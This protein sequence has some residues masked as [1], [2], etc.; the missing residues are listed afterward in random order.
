MKWC[1]FDIETRGQESDFVLGAVYSDQAQLTAGD[2]DTFVEVLKAHAQQGYVLVAHNAEFDVVNSLWRAGQD[3]TIH[4]YNSTFTTAYWFHHRRK[5]SCQIWDSLNLAAGVSLAELGR[6]LGYPKLP[7]PQ[8]LRGLDPDRYEWICERHDIGEC[9]DCYCLRDA[10]IVYRFVSELEGFLNGYGLDMRR[11]IAANAVQLWKLLDP[12]RQQTVRS[13]RIRELAAKALHG[14]RVEVYQHG[15]FGPVHT[16]DHRNHYMATMLA[17]PMPDC[18]FLIHAKGW[19]RHLKWERVEGVIDA[20]VYQPLTRFPVLPV[21]HGERIYYPVGLF[22]G[23]WSIAE[24]RAALDRGAELRQVYELS[25]SDRVVY[26][27]TGMMGALLVLEEELRG[28]NDAR[29]TVVKTL[30]NAIPGRLGMTT[31]GRRQIYRRR[32]PGLRERDRIGAELAYSAGT[33]YLI[34][35]HEVPRPPDTSNVLWG[36]LVTAQGRLR[37]LAALEAAGD[38]AIYGDTDSVFTTVPISGTGERHGDLR[39]TGTYASGQFLS[40]KMYRL[41]PFQGDDVLKAKGVPR[42]VVE[43]YFERGQVE[44]DSNLGV[45][46][47]LAMDRQPGT[48]MQVRRERSLVPARRQLLNPAA[49]VDQDQDSDTEPVVFGPEGPVNGGKG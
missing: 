11:T 36:S 42:Q 32:T 37:Q 8:R 17:S 21:V 49:L 46:R 22:R 29:R 44:Y 18:R 15:R 24:L 7:M 16:Y 6:S 5:P 40:P 26:P 10:E 34:K 19:P 47:A 25:W 28:R 43:A 48:W 13:E 1:A 20:L 12:D 30:G 27:F 38:S 9:P 4:Y 31:G 39:D 33:A 23:T 35:E 3:V 14:G 2:L 45:I 41:E